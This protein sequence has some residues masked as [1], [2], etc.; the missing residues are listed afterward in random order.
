MCCSQFGDFKLRMKLKVQLYS[1]EAGMG[2]TLLCKKVAADWT[3]EKL[4]RLFSFIFVVDLGETKPKQSIADAILDQCPYLKDEGITSAEVEERLGD[5]ATLLVLDGYEQ[6]QHTQEVDDIVSGRRYR[7]CCLILTSR[8]HGA[9]KLAYLMQVKVTL[10]GFSRENRFKFLAQQLGNQEEAEHFEDSIVDNGLETLIQVPLFALLLCQ[11]YK[12]RKTAPLPTTR[13]LMFD[14]LMAS[15]KLHRPLQGLPNEKIAVAKQVLSELAC[16]ALVDQTKSLIC[17]NTTLDHIQPLNFLV[18]YSG[19]HKTPFTSHVSFTHDAFK[20]YFAAMGIA[21]KHT[22]SVLDKVLSTKM[23]D[24]EQFLDGGLFFSLLLGFGNSAANTRVLQHL[25]ELYHDKDYG[26]SSA[27]TFPVDSR[28]FF[29]DDS[30]CGDTTTDLNEIAVRLLTHNTK[31]HES[32]LCS[33]LPLCHNLYKECSDRQHAFSSRPLCNTAIYIVDFDTE[34]DPGDL[35]AL[36]IEFIPRNVVFRNFS[37]DDNIAFPEINLVKHAESNQK[38]SRSSFR[39]LDS[40]WNSTFCRDFS[41]W[42]RTYEIKLDRVTLT[43]LTVGVQPDI[44]NGTSTP[45]SQCSRKLATALIQ[46]S[47]V[48]LVFVAVEFKQ[49]LWRDVTHR[50][51][52]SENT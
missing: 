16:K 25:G 31:K 46:P 4:P 14:Q 15:L 17:K 40:A 39:A 20:Y 10:D 12:H 36:S 44:E 42:I 45:Y 35:Q 3:C 6:L 52:V 28:V 7:N 48:Q 23:N 32:D 34:V 33:I 5:P 26:I 29:D 38:F 9:N 18:R 50:L 27:S 47:L 11:I 21:E 13:K 8:P 30:G 43:G 51:Q 41:S 2:K 24:L 37:S 1:F 22:T 49:I 19:Q